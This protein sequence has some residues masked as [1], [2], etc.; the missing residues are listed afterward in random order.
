MRTEKKC[1]YHSQITAISSYLVRAIWLVFT[2]THTHTNMS[3]VS[4]NFHQISSYQCKIRAQ[5]LLI[6]RYLVVAFRFSCMWTVIVFGFVLVWGFNYNFI[7]FICL[8]LCRSHFSTSIFGYLFRL[9][10]YQCPFSMYNIL[11][12]SLPTKVPVPSEQN[13]CI[14]DAVVDFC[15]WFEL[16]Y[17]VSWSTF[18]W[19]GLSQLK[20]VIRETNN[21]R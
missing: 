7:C 14:F 3:I 1:H 8:S 2:N 12:T 10:P 18:G 21:K 20:Y 16:I 5:Y 9:L 4:G 15:A 6:G 17:L 13:I 19:N 11:C